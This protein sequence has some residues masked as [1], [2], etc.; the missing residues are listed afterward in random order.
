[1]SSSRPAVRGISRGRTIGAGRE[2]ADRH[3]RSESPRSERG[4]PGGWATRRAAIAGSASRRFLEGRTGGPALHL[5][6]A[7]AKFPCNCPRSQMKT[8]S[9]TIAA[10]LAPSLV[11]AGSDRLSRRRKRTPPKSSPR[12]APAT[13]PGSS[14]PPS[15]IRQF[16]RPSRWSK[17]PRSNGK[18]SKA[19]Q[20]AAQQGI[21]GG[22][23]VPGSIRRARPI[24]RS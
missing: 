2:S 20:M 9:L 22:G 23:A 19:H 1:M 24:I 5:P 16:R 6:L 13:P 14:P 7:D 3:C 4:V 10:V 21:H 11:A 18:N 12:P 15:K 17:E 8:N